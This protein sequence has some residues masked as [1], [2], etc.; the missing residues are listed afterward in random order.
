MPVLASP[1]FTGIYV[2]AVS[3]DGYLVVLN[4]KDG[5]I[6]EK[7]YINSKSNPGSMGLSLSSPLVHNNRLYVGSETGGITCFKGVE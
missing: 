3:Q 5:S 7:H 4:G 1:S 6:I 2:Y